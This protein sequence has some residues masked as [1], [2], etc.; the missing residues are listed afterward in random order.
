M[1]FVNIL[2]WHELL[3]NHS[4]CKFLQM[5]PHEK[6]LDMD[7][8]DQTFYSLNVVFTCC[9]LTLPPQ[10]RPEPV[11][12][13]SS[14]ALGL[15]GG[16]GT[17]TFSQVEACTSRYGGEGTLACQSSRPRPVTFR[18]R[19]R[20]RGPAPGCAAPPRAPLAP[21]RAPPASLS[22]PPPPRRA[23]PPSRLCS[24]L[25]RLF[26]LA[27]WLHAPAPLRNLASLVT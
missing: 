3:K 21:L 25:P 7:F 23:A 22:A 2:S 1:F 18:P 15:T 9:Q 6:P 24:P 4:G 12:L 5:F 19:P 17:C 20:R 11:S 26:R 27:R 14:L 16:N 10:C 13:Q 8:L